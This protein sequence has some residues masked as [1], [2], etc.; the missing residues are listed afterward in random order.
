MS[1]RAKLRKGKKLEKYERDFYRDNQH[2]VDFR[3]RYTDE[4]R[5]EQERLLALLG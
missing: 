1:I 3:A 5:A 2:L 4:E